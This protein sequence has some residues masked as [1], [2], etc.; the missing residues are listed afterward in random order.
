MD[1]SC[2]K[3]GWLPCLICAHSRLYT[4][5]LPLHD[6]SIPIYQHNMLTSKACVESHGLIDSL[7]TTPS[8]IKLHWLLFF[9]YQECIYKSVSWQPTTSCHRL[10]CHSLACFIL[11][12]LPSLTRCWK[13]ERKYSIAECLVGLSLYG[14]GDDAEQWGWKAL[15][16]FLQVQMSDTERDNPTEVCLGLAY[17][18]GLGSKPLMGGICLLVSI[19]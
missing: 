2:E 3:M 18:L 15:G 5:L 19:T 12:T 6:T 4:V 7:P 17:L 16:I 14:W 1:V 9:Y 8:P 13:Q 11:V 10:H